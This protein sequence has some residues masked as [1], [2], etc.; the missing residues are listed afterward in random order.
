MKTLRAELNRASY[1]TCEEANTACDAFVDLIA[2]QEGDVIFLREFMDLAG[3]ECSEEFSG[4]GWG[5]D[6]LATA[7][8]DGDIYT[9]TGFLDYKWHINV[10][11]PHILEG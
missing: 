11:D 7:I 6:E 1:E 8:A 4:Y 5:T 10:P 9:Y 2:N 3:V